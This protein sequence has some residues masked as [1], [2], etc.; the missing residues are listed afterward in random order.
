MPAGGSTY[1][2]SASDGAG[3]GLK[4]VSTCPS[5]STLRR[6]GLPEL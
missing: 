5:M 1:E 6:F 2:C 4:P 3:N